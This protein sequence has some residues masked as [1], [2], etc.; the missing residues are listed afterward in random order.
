MQALLNGKLD[1]ATT[2]KRDDRVIGTIR[3]ALL[4]EYRA[5]SEKFPNATLESIWNTSVTGLAAYWAEDKPR[6]L[7][8]ETNCECD[9]YDHFRAVGSGAKSAHAAWR[10]LGAEQL[11]QLREGMA[12]QAMFRILQVCIETEVAGVSG[13]IVMWVI[14]EDKARRISDTE[15][16]ALQE[17][18]IRDFLFSLSNPR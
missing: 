12:L 13:P 7:E 3:S 16:D 1:H 8:I 4:P 14:T 10:A 17:V 5:L 18:A 2:F 9:A 6:I 11:S 15:M